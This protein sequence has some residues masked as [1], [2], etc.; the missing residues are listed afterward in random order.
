MPVTEA[1]RVADDVLRQGVRGISDIITVQLTA[2][3]SHA[4]V[5]R[6]ILILHNAF[7]DVNKVGLRYGVR[8]ASAFISRHALTCCCKQYFNHFGSTFGCL[9]GVSTA[10]HE[11]P[12]SS[13]DGLADLPCAA[14]PS[15]TQP[16]LASFTYVHSGIPGALYICALQLLAT[17][18]I[19]HTITAA[20][21]TKKPS[22][23]IYQCHA[24]VA[25][26]NKCSPAPD[27]CKLQIPQL[28]GSVSWCVCA[29]R[30]QAW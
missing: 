27:L 16:C 23:A 25:F 30:C 13:C 17:L 26:C 24:A 29:C 7:R 4:H 3:C 14:L 10:G 18:E 6:C 28:S 9:S 1:F 15:L 5:Q 11:Y 12:A 2:W 8:H 19:K 20:T 21:Q 22:S